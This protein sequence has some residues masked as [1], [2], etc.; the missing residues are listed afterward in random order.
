MPT[1][2]CKEITEGQNSQPTIEYK[3]SGNVILRVFDAYSYQN[4]GEYVTIAN[5][6]YKILSSTTDVE[7]FITVYTL[8]F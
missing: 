2:K 8:T 4:V 7:N 3:L 1:L 6:T 5:A